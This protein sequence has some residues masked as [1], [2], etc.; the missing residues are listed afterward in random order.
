MIYASPSRQ[1]SV[2]GATLNV[3]ITK[4]SW[5]KNAR[6]RGGELAHATGQ[7]DDRVKGLVEWEGGPGSYVLTDEGRPVRGAAPTAGL[8]FELPETKV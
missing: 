3:R 6:P 1:L 4:T 7:Q 2:Q 5:R 8:P